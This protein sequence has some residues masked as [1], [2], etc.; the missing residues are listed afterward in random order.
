MYKPR[1]RPLEIRCGHCLFKKDVLP[2]FY[3]AHR[4]KSPQLFEIRDPN[5]CDPFF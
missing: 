5:I 3:L 1:V 4:F 2:H